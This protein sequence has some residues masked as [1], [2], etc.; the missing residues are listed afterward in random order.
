MKVETLF[1]CFL[2]ALGFLSVF[3]A[4]SFSL[5]G[6]RFPWL[7]SFILLSLVLLQG[8]A[9]ARRDAPQAPRLSRESL[10]EF[11]RS[12]GPVIFWSAAGFFLIYFFG[13]VAGMFLLVLGY[14]LQQ[15]EKW[16]TALAYAT[17]MGLLTYFG[18]RMA[19]QMDLYPGLIAQ[20]LGF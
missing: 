3:I 5:A 15:K 18:F 16:L 17:G 11:L 12:H 14:Q 20:L 6:R 7:V 10:R 1:L 9:I 2:A 13:F 4:S 19:L 8:L